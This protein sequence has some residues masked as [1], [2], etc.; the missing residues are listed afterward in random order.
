MPSL[1][2]KTLFIPQSPPQNQAMTS[3]KNPQLVT[4]DTFRATVAPGSKP[5]APGDGCGLDDNGRVKPYEGWSRFCGFAETGGEAGSVVTIRHRGNFRLE[6]SGAG[7]KSRGQAK[8]YAHGPHDFR[9]V[10]P[11]N[12]DDTSAIVGFLNVAGDVVVNR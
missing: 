11:M 6:V 7:V 12:A 5:I 1:D 4:G 3:S 10:E 8:V 9:T 2:F